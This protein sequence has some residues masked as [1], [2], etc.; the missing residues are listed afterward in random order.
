[1]LIRHQ[2]S[3]GVHK[4]KRIA[5]VVVLFAVLGGTVTEVFALSAHAAADNSVVLRSGAVDVIVEKGLS[6]GAGVV[7]FSAQE[8]T[9][10]LSRVLGSEVSVRAEPRPGVPAIMLGDVP[11]ARNA[12][13]RVL[14][15]PYD[16]FIVKCVPP[17]R[18]FI[19]GFDDDGFTPGVSR[20]VRRGTL[21]GVY[22]F[23]E[24]YAGCRF[25]FPGELGEVVP[26]RDV[27]MV[28][29][30]ETVRHPKFLVRQIPN[31]LGSWFDDVSEKER[32]RLQLLFY[33]RI[34]AQTLYIPCVHGQVSAC[35][36]ERFGKTHPE[37]FLLRRDGTRFTEPVC[38]AS[39]T[40]VGQMCHSSGI[41]DEIY[42]DA[43]AYFQGKPASS[44]GIPGGRW[45]NNARY[46]KYFDVMPQ[47]GMVRCCCERC[48]RAY[49]RAKHPDDWA[50]ELIWG[51]VAQ[52]AN[53]LIAEGVPGTLTMMSYVNYRRVPEVQ[54]PTNVAV[55]VCSNDPWLQPEDAAKTFE[56]LKQ[57]SASRGGNVWLW[58]NN[59]KHAWYSLNISDVPTLTPRAFGAYYRK[60]APYV[61]GAY[62]SNYAER[63]LYSALNY[64]VF[65]KVG[66]DPSIDADAVIDEYYDLMFGRAAGTMRQAFDRLERKWLTE[67]IGRS[68]EIKYGT[69]IE[70]P[71]N[72][73]VWTKLYSPAC[74]RPFEDLFDA[75]AREVEPGSI[76]AR[77]LA[78]MRR[79]ILDPL[80]A[81]SRRYASSV[82]VAEE[83]KR[84][85]LRTMD[86]LISGAGAGAVSVANVETNSPFK[87]IKY[88]LAVKPG[89]AYRLSFF[90]HGRDIVRFPRVRRYGAQAIVWF[91]Q[92]RDKVLAETEMVDGTF[93]D[94]HLSA[95]FT[96]PADAGCDAGFRPELDMRMFCAS[97][98]FGFS[99][100]LLEECSAPVHHSQ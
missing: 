14:D 55:M 13:L 52:T 65:C 48:T 99:N 97:G 75:A 22:H 60:C 79:E 8:M 46:G 85:S 95:T 64:Y 3:C 33:Y 38:R 81:R 43:K 68:Y 21:F 94:V 70:V 16:G 77:R 87:A 39:P 74:I 80:V 27:V 92:S 51:R 15:L 82:S 62:A 93:G 69:S 9:N 12:G 61:F 53:R 50:N 4:V 25:Y 40:R 11:S 58:N 28:P 47:D 44:R 37:Y 91:D 30:G 63:F 1:M 36:P 29:C 2:A 17:D 90:A 45:G 83:R 100:L 41:W 18:L 66:W 57:W 10:F 20:L 96:V 5:S 6:R 89:R 56:N 71:H 31:R 78:L 86:N 23:L 84:R 35:F 26:R 54:I 24:R 32:N 98:M 34:G 67:I 7:A 88:P 72:F 19:A 73:T 42:E 76:E 59:G 49:A